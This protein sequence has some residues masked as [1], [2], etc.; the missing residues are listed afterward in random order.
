MPPSHEPWLRVL[1]HTLEGK[2]YLKIF[3]MDEW[4]LREA[5]LPRSSG[6]IFLLE[7][8]SFTLKIPQKQL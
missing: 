4:G 6:L 3:F 5:N 2:L 7:L 1:S 8:A